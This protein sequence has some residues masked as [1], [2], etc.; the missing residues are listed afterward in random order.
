MG[1]GDFIETKKSNDGGIDGIIN[2]DKLGIDKIYI[3][4]KK[5]TES[6]V[7]EKD[8]RNPIEL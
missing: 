6:K 4:A 2:E 1:Y 3:Q 5:Y 7:N 8:I